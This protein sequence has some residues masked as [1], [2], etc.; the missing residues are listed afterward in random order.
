MDKDAKTILWKIWLF[1]SILT[2]GFSFFFA[3]IGLISFLKQPQ[4]GDIP[5]IFLLAAVGAFFFWTF[6]RTRKSL[7]AL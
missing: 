2:A 4:S 5:A 1:I 7:K 6:L 3:V